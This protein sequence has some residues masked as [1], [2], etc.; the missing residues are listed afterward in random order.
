MDKIYGLTERL[1]R[2][3]SFVAIIEASAREALKEMAGG[4]D[5]AKV[6]DYV[7]EIVRVN[8]DMKTQLALCQTAAQDVADSQLEEPVKKRARKK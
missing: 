3:D 4:G 8:G 7:L 5:A 6:A 2:A 1:S